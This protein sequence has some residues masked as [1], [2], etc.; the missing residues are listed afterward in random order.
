[1]RKL[2]LPEDLITL[3][4]ASKIIGVTKRIIWEW[5]DKELLTVYKSSDGNGTIFISKKELLDIF[6]ERQYEIF[7]RQKG[8]N[9]KTSCDVKP[10][11][12]D[13]DISENI[14]VKMSTFEKE[15]FTCKEA[16][17]LIGCGT[18]KLRRWVLEGRAK[19]SAYYTYRTSY[20]PMFDLEE[21]ER[22]EKFEI[23]GKRP[24]VLPSITHKMSKVFEQI[25][26]KKGYTSINPSIWEIAKNMRDAYYIM[27]LVLKSKDEQSVLGVLPY[28]LFSYRNSTSYSQQS[29]PDEQIRNVTSFEQE[30]A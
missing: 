4:Q 17:I 3:T 2:S 21:I 26:N 7:R 8:Q 15:L 24:P 28:A 9:S 27:D 22:L 10:N 1:M 12:L 6:E 11:P 13:L 5:C 25:L 16:S 23:E 20:L 19:A 30:S 18:A 14:L 29:I